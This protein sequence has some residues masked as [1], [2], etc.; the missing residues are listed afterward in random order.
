MARIRPRSFQAFNARNIDSIPQMRH[1]SDE[2][3]LGIKAVA[4]V[5]PFRVNNYVVDELIHWD[6]V[7]ED[8]IFRLTFPQPG[9]LER[10]DFE[11]LRRLLRL[12]ASS[13]T[14]RKAARAI[15]LK[16]NP[17]PA[18]QIE[19]NVPWANGRPIPGMQHKYRETVLFFPSQG[20]T[21]HTYCTYCFRWAQF[22]GIDEL[23]FANRQVAMLVEYLRAHPEVSSV[24]FTGGDPLV[25]K[26]ALLR[27]YVEPLLDPALE[28]IVSIRIG[29]K[30]PAYWPYRFL[31]DPDAA[32]LLRLFEQVQ[33]SGKHLALMAHYSHPR[34][35]DTPEAQESLRRIHRTGAVVRCQAPL[36]RGVNDDSHTW[37]DMW[38]M[39]V[40]LGAV[41][42]YMFIERDTGPKNYFEVPL[43]RAV[44]VF[45]RAYR[46]VSGI[47]RTVR[48]P[49]MSATPGKVVVRGSAHVAGEEVFVLEFVQ[50]RDP[51]WVGRPFFARFDETASW[52]DDLV[53]A[54][55]ESEFF[56]SA[57]MREIERSRHAPAWG[58][59]IV[60]R[61]RATVFGHV[62][63]E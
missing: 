33:R 49:S 23:K 57:R 29:T 10:G 34:E 1:L 24:L 48:G 16:L 18:G 51:A 54:L 39:Q 11:R 30:A 7:P 37:A 27:R 35:L 13:E 2:E 50:A 41:P 15:Q 26:T 42:Y 38:R 47:A 31:T 19:L 40:R 8:P 55:G 4:A 36:I 6:E 28:H 62:E 61:R 17:H 52:L 14:I 21:C 32:D 5:L 53:P 60:R 25:M 46:R 12:N 43:A 58:D 9:M 44:Q 56:F 3:L 45:R 63:W 59:R 20:Q 22:V